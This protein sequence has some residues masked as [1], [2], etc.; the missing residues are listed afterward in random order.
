MPQSND[1]WARQF[2]EATKEIAKLYD[3]FDT[4]RE[5]APLDK[6]KELCEGINEAY[7]LS[8]DLLD[9]VNLGRSLLGKH[10]L[11]SNQEHCYGN[12]SK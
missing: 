5:L 1:W 10:D 9:F 7:D 6:A 11:P 4:T 3:L 8:L 2:V 12:H